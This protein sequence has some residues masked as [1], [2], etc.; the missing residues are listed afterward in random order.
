VSDGLAGEVAAWNCGLGDKIILY[1]VV[2]Q[3]KKSWKGL[4]VAKPDV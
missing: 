3:V 1:T 4:Y 2:E